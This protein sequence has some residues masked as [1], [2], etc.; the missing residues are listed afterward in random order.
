MTPR[1]CI[2]LCR[3]PIGSAIGAQPSDNLTPG[4]FRGS[5][6]GTW[7]PLAV[8]IRI[9]RGLYHLLDIRGEGGYV[10]GSREVACLVSRS[11]NGRPISVRFA[12]VSEPTDTL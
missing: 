2:V 1:T 3:Y 8:I 11:W 12:V 5:V 9:A 6:P 4:F 7:A 10:A